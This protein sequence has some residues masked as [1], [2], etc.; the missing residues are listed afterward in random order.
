MRGV[1]QVIKYIKVYNFFVGIL[2]FINKHGFIFWVKRGINWFIVLMFFDILL[3]KKKTVLK[4]FHST[5]IYL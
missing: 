5:V 4:V 2:F 3:D 1:N